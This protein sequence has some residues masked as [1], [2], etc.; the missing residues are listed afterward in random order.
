MRNARIE[1]ALAASLLVSACTEASAPTVL[2]PPP[3]GLRSKPQWLTY[4]CVEPGCETTRITSIS[5]LGSRDV[6][7]K[8]IVLSEEDREDFELV[9]SKEPPF[10]LQASET[11]EIQA[12]YRP[13]GD[14]RLRDV[15]ISVTYTDAAVSDDDNRI[16]PGEL[17]IPL[18]RRLIGEPKLSVN[19]TQLVFGSVLAGGNKTMPLEIANSGFGN[20]GVVV[21][22]VTT[23]VP[24]ISISNLPTLAVLPETTWDV[25]VTYSP[26]EEKYT[27]GLIT[28]VSADSTAKPALVG[29]YG[30][31]IPRPTI[32]AIPETGIDFGEVRVGTTAMA[33]VE[34]YNQ[35]SDVLELYRAI[36]NGTGTQ[37]LSL[38]LPG[39]TETTTVAVLESV[40]A[41]VVLEGTTAGVIE[42]EILVRNNDRANR[43]F[44]IPVRALVTKPTVQV[45]PGSVNFG[46]VPRGWRKTERI[47]VENSGYGELLVSELASVVGSSDLFTIQ[48]LPRFPISL[49][50][51]ERFSFEIEFRSEAQAE[52]NGVIA[53]ESND[54]EYPYRELNLTAR[55]ASCEEGCPI[56]NGT[57]TC[58]G[59]ACAIDSCNP[60]WYDTDQ[61]A[62]TGCECAEI[63]TDPGDFCASSHWAGNLVDDGDAATVSGII[64]EES[65]VDLITFFAI[66]EGGV[67]Q[68]FGDDFDVRVRLESGDPTIEMCV[69]RHNTAQH[70]TSCLMQNEDCGRNFR[71]DGS[72]GSND[73][74]DYIV[75]IFRRPGEAPICTQYTVFIRNG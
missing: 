6:A 73:N 37:G 1:L 33:T 19:P 7:I 22:S 58:L 61:D 28:V 70:E 18:V 42:A 45:S 38:E 4:S 60:G 11:F 17:Q 9:L 59:G 55:G 3:P 43:D 47:E 54:P 67:G 8:R 44:K 53:I 2:E 69:Y 25:D 32:A 75:K 74:G 63:G 29:V 27:E 35:G 26:T 14:P 21:E 13:T 15:E 10:V 52:F 66:D 71:R 51:Q 12:T 56:T 65:D 24:E 34:I 50:H 64:S 49:R 46:V 20:V 48:N 68:L 36:I 41:T 39:G 72:Y 40:V 57:P 5:V 30:T 23:D 62:S 16:E 31:S